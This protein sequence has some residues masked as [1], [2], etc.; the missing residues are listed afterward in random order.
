MLRLSYSV[1]EDKNFIKTPVWGRLTVKGGEYMTGQEDIFFRR[2]RWFEV[3]LAAALTVGLAA[4]VLC[5]ICLYQGRIQPDASWYGSDYQAD[6]EI[7]AAEALYDGLYGTVTYELCD[8]SRLEEAKIWQNGY[9]AGGFCE[10]E[11]TLTVSPGDTLELD[12]AAYRRPVRVRLKRASTGINM[13]FLLSDV[14]ICG[15]RIDLGRVVF[16]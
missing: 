10:P 3:W 7:V 13:A 6:G 9:D 8:Y 15:G 4:L 14:E 11:L 5:Q 12:A 2:R 16:E 1:I